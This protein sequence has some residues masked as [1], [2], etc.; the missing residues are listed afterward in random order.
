MIAYRQPYFTGKDTQQPISDKNKTNSEA[1]NSN[2]NFF[3]LEQEPTILVQ[4]KSNVPKTTNH[5]FD[6]SRSQ[7]RSNNKPQFAAR[8]YHFHWYTK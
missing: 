2:Q 6:K 8:G 3:K 1:Q 4:S 7:N 5:A